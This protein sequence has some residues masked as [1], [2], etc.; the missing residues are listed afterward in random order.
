MPGQESRTEEGLDQ[1]LDHLQWADFA[2]SRHEFIVSSVSQSMAKSLGVTHAD[3]NIKRPFSQYGVDSIT[4][5]DL[6]HQINTHL[7]IVLR[8]TT[9][10]D[11]ANIFDL[12]CFI[13]QNHGTAIDEQRQHPKPKLSKTKDAQ[14]HQERSYHQ[15]IAL[16]RP[17]RIEELSF[18]PLK[19]QEPAANEVQIA[20]RAFSLNF[21]DLLCVK[22]LYP[23]MPEYPFT[24]GFEVS[25]HIA[26]LGSEVSRFVVGDEVIAL[27]GDQLG[28][29]STLLTTAEHLVVSKPREVSHEDACAFPGVFLTVYHAFQKANIKAGEKVLIQGAAG[30]TGLIAVQMALAAGAEIYAT[31][32]SRQKLDYLRERGVPHLINYQTDDFAEVILA[33]TNGY[34]VDVVFNTAAG[35]AIQKGLDILAPNGRY[36]EIAMVALKRSRSLDLSHLVDNQVFYS[37]DMRKLVAK[38]PQLISRYLDRMVEQ[39]AEGSVKPT[40]GARFAI[41]DI[42]KAYRLLEDRKN[43][44]KVVVS[45]PDMIW[46]NHVGQSAVPESSAVED[47]VPESSPVESATAKNLVEQDDPIAVVGMSGRFPGA[48]NLDQF[49]LNLASGKS[50]ITEVPAER[51]DLNQWYDP[52]PAV[53]N[54]THC[55][56]GGFLHDIDKF[57]AL[58]FKLSGREAELTDPQQ[59]LFLEVSWA[60]LEDA[61][62]A[63][64][65]ISNTRCGV[66]VGAGPSDYSTLMREQGVPCEPQSFWGNS[67]S[68]IASRISYFLNLKGPSITIDTACS[69]SLVALHLGCQSI[70]RGECDMVIAGGVYIG[71]TPHFHIIASNAGMLS[72]DGRCKTFDQSAD[73]FVPGEGVGAVVLKPLSAALKAGNFIYGLIRG[74]GSNQDGRTYGIT[75]PSAAS[76]MELEQ[77]V[78]RHAKLDPADISYV[79]AHGT[80]TKLGDPIEIDALSNAFQSKTKKHHDCAIGSVKTNIGHAGAAAGIAGLIKVLLCLQHRQLVPSLNYHTRN[81][82]IDFDNSPFYVNTRLKNWSVA[83]GDLRRAV[84]S[85]FGFSGT[86]AHILLEEYKQKAIAVPGIG[87]DGLGDDRRGKGAGG[88]EQGEQSLSRSRSVSLA[89]PLVEKRSRE[90]ERNMGIK[91]RPSRAFSIGRSTRSVTTSPL[92]PAPRSPA[93]FDKEVLIVLSAK[94]Q[95][96]L[97]KVAENLQSFLAGA[98]SDQ[99]EDIAYTLQVGR[100]A[101]ETRVAFVVDSV[102]HFQQKLAAFLKDQT[103]EEGFYQGQ[104]RDG[105]G[106]PG[107]GSS[108]DVSLALANKQLPQLAHWWVSGVELDWRQLRGA[109]QG[110]LIPL[111]TYPFARDRYW[112]DSAGS[113]AISQAQPSASVLHPLLH[114]LDLQA[115]AKIEKGCVFETWLKSSDP[116]LAQH[117]IE[118]KAV[119]PAVGFLEMIM[120]GLHEIQPDQVALLEDVFWLRPLDVMDQ[121]RV[122]L[123]LEVEQ[124]SFQYRIIPAEGDG[125]VYC[126]GNGYWQKEANPAVQ[127]DVNRLKNQMCKQSVFPESDISVNLGSLYQGATEGWSDGQQALIAFDLPTTSGDRQAP[128]PIQYQFHPAAFVAALQAYGW[129][130]SAPEGLG[131]PFAVQKVELWSDRHQAVYAHVTQDENGKMDVQILDARGQVSV[132][133]RGITLQTL[134]NADQKV[135][136]ETA[137]KNQLEKLLF[138]P[139]WKRLDPKHGVESVWHRPGTSVLL[140]YAHESI[141]EAEKL[142]QSYRQQE[143]ELLCVCL[144]AMENEIDKGLETLAARLRQLKSPLGNICFLD[145]NSQRLD[146]A[147]MPIDESFGEPPTI[148]GLLALVRILN[149]LGYSELPLQWLVLTYRAYAVDQEDPTAPYATAIVGLVSCLAQ[150]HRH[151]QVSVCDR[152]DHTSPWGEYADFPAIANN[153]QTLQVIAQR[154]GHGYVR[155]LEQLDL[156][157]PTQSRLRHKGVYVLVGGA[158]HVGT[159][160]SRY[161]VQTYQAKVIWLG[162]REQN[163]QI[164]KKIAMIAALGSRPQY[165]RLKT[166]SEDDLKR[167]FAQIKAENSMIHGVFNLV[168]VAQGTPIRNLSEAQF[169]AGS[170]DSKVNS[171]Q[172]LYR[173]LKNEALDFMVFFSS[174]QSFAQRLD[175]M[176]AN[177]SSYVAGCMFQDAFVH[178]MNRQLDYPV[179]TINWGY[180]SQ[181]STG[182]EKAQWYETY[183]GNKGVFSLRAGEAMEALERILVNE[184]EQVMVAKVSDE[185]LSDMGFLQDRTVTVSGQHSKE[186]E[187][188]N[189]HLEILIVNGILKTLETLGVLKIFANPCDLEKPRKQAHVLDKYRRLWRELILILVGAGKMEQQGSLFTL[190]ESYGSLEKKIRLIDLEGDARLLGDRYPALASK[191]ALLTPCLNGMADVLNARKQATEV[192]FEHSSLSRVE[193]IYR[194]NPATDYFNQHVADVVTATVQQALPSL[195]AGEKIR[196]LEIGAGT[197]GTSAFLFKALNAY[198]DQLRYIYT[199]ISKRFLIHAQETFCE[200]YSFVETQLLNI[201]EA[202]AE[203]GF[204]PGSI[205]IVV[206]ANVL[207]AT[208]NIGRTLQN[209][210][211]LLKGDGLLVLNELGEVSPFLTVTFGLLDGWWLYDDETIR[212]PGSPAL[213][214]KNWQLMLEKQHFHEVIL[215]DEKAQTLG[216]QIIIAQN[217]GEI[218]EAPAIAHNQEEVLSI[219]IAASVEASLMRELSLCIKIEQSRLNTYTTFSDYGVDS[220]LMLAFVDQINASLGIKLN[221]SELFNY[222]TVERL[223]GFIVDR[224][225]KELSALKQAAQIQENKSE[226]KVTAKAKNQT[227]D[228]A[229]NSPDHSKYWS[230]NVDSHW[231]SPLIP[232]QKGENKEFLAPLL[233]GGW[234]DQL[235]T[236]SHREDNNK[237]DRGLHDIAIIGMSG[238]FPGATNTEQFWQNLSAG[239]HSV[240]ELPESRLDRQIYSPQLETG[241]CYCKWGGI[242]EE[243]AYFDPLFFEISPKEAAEMNPSQRVF[244]QEAYRALEDAGLVN[245]GLS[246]LHCGVYVGCEPNGYTKQGFTGS[247]EALVASRISYFLN[248]QGPAL[249]INSGCS[250]SLVAIHLACESL[251]HGENDIALAGGVFTNLNSELLVC[252]SSIEMLSS[253]GKCCAFD[254]A[255]NGTVLGEGVSV[256]VLKKLQSALDDGDLIYGVI[257][258]S[259]INQ[260]GKSN[261]ITAPNGLAQEKLIKRI[262]QDYKIDASKISY[263]EAHGT[264]TKLG[265]PVEANALKK[266]FSSINPESGFHCGVGSVKSNIG[267]PAAAAGAI[268]LVKVL[269]C[270]KH[271][272]LP[273]LVHFNQLNPFI[274]FNDTGLYIV[275]QL[276]DWEAEPGEPLM[277]GINSFGHS[278]TNAHLVIQEAPVQ[279]INDSKKAFYLICLSAKT[280]EALKHKISDLSEYLARQE[281]QVTLGAIAY[282]LNTG[283]A[284]FKKRCA[285]VVDSLEALQDALTG[286]LEGLV[287]NGSKMSPQEQAFAKKVF[288]LIVAD[289]QNTGNL[290]TGSDQTIYKDNLMA[291][292]GLY[293]KGF[294]LDWQR[295]YQGQV[296]RRL[297][298][299]TYPFAKEAYWINEPQKINF[300]EPLADKPKDQA[301]L[302]GQF[303]L[304]QWKRLEKGT[305]D[306]GLGTGDWE[307]LEG[308]T[309][310]NLVLFAERLVEKKTLPSPQSPVPSPR[311]PLLADK[312]GRS[313]GTL[314]RPVELEGDR[315]K[316]A[317]TPD[318]VVI[319][320]PQTMSGVKDDLKKCYEQASASQVVSFEVGDTFASELNV[321][322][323]HAFELAL[324]SPKLG[325]SALLEPGQ[326]LTLYFLMPEA[327]QALNLELN[328]QRLE[329]NQSRGL[330]ALFRLIQA[331]LADH[332]YSSELTLKIVTQQTQACK[333]SERIAPFGADVVG[334]VQSLTK[335]YELW[336]VSCVDI[337]R[338]TLW[339]REQ[340]K[341]F[342][343][344]LTALKPPTNGRVICWREGHFYHNVLTQANLSSIQGSSFKTHGVY[345]IIGGAGGLGLVLSEYL[346][347]TVQAKL[348]W[349][350]RRSVEALTPLAQQLLT[351]QGAKVL[352]QQGDIGD[353]EAMRRVV[354]QAKAHFG[355]LDGVIHSALVLEDRAIA[356]MDE[357]T[358][359]KVLTPKVQGNVVLQQAL[360]DEPLDFLLFFS[361][362]Q[363]FMSHAGQSN[364]ASACTFED[365]WAQSQNQQQNYPVKVINWGYWGEVGI[366]ATPDHRQR[367]ARQG[368]LSINPQEGMEVV[369]RCLASCATQVAYFKA[370]PSTLSRLGLDNGKIMYASQKSVSPALIH[371]VIAATQ[372]LSMSLP[373]GQRYQQALKQLDRLGCY[374]L[375]RAFQTMGVFCQPGE[376]YEQQALAARLG[377]PE[378]YYQLY[379]E[380]LNLLDKAGFI[381]M[382]GLHL[383]VQTTLPPENDEHHNWLKS[384]PELRSHEKLLQICVQAYP[385]IIQ[386]SV[387]ATDIMFPE[388]SME[389]VEGIYQGNT[390]A[391]ALNTK[392]RD[393]AIAYVKA[394]LADCQKESGAFMQSKIIF[395]EVGAGTGGMSSEVLKGLAPYREY[396]EYY[397]TDISEH[398]VQYGRRRYGEDYPFVRFQR[399]D[400]EQEREAVSDG[401]PNA[402]DVV[403][404]ANVLHA[405]QRVRNTIQHVKALLKR[406]GLLI[407]NEVTTITSFATLTF[408]LLEGWWRYQ[409]AI[410]RM[411]G[412]P[413]LSAPMWHRLLEEEG[414]AKVVSL[415]EQGEGE[416]LGQQIIVGQSDGWSLRKNTQKQETQSKEA[417]ERGAGSKGEVVTD[418]VLRPIENALEGRGLIPMF[419][420][421][422][423]LLFSTRGCANETLRER[424]R[425]CSPCS[426][427]PAPPPLL[428]KQTEPIAITQVKNAYSPAQLVQKVTAQI[429]QTLAE[430]LDIAS[431]RVELDVPFSEYGVDSILSVSIINQLNQRLG[432][433]LKRPDLFNYTT[434]ESMAAH[435]VETF[436]DRLTESLAENTEKPSAVAAPKKTQSKSQT[437]QGILQTNQEPI[438][439]IGMSACL[440]GADNV[441]TFWDNLV[442]GKNSVTQI[443]R[444]RYQRES[445]ND[446]PGSPD[447]SQRQAGFMANIAEF[448]PLFFA[449]S[450]QEA[451]WMDPAQRLFLQQA[452]S[453]LEDAGYNPRALEGT[454]C[455]V[456]VGCS[457]TGYGVKEGERAGY[458]PYAMTNSEAILPAR[459]SY[460]LDLKGPSIPINTACSSSLVAIHLA[461]EQLRS[462]QSDIALAGGASALIGSA[463]HIGLK[464][465]GMLS[466]DGLCKA[467]DRGANGFVL[468]EAVGVVVLKPLSSALADGDSIHGLIIGSAINQDGK[469]NGIMAPN[470]P[471]QTA[472]IESVYR[473]FQ[474]DPNTI[475]YIETHGTGTQLGDPIEVNALAAAYQKFTTQ[476]QYCAIGSVKTNIGHTTTAAGVCGLIKTLLCLKNKKLVP[477]LHYNQPNENI[478]FAQTPF[479]VNTQVKDWPGDR[480]GIRCAAVSSF[481]YSGTNAHIVVEEF[482]ETRTSTVRQ[483]G[484]ALIVLSARN[485]ARLK[486]LASNLRADL[487][488]N[489]QV[490]LADVAY[491]LQVGRQAMSER[492]AFVADSVTDIV[493]HLADFLDGKANTQDLYQGKVKSA[494]DKSDLLLEGDAGQAFINTILKQQDYRKLATLWVAGTSWDWNLLYGE[495][496]PRR[497]SLPSYPFARE[498]YWLDG[499]VEAKA[500][501][502]IPILYEDAP[503]YMRNEPQRAQRTQREKERKFGAASQRNG[504]TRDQIKR[505]TQIEQSTEL[506]TFEEVWQE[507]PLSDASSS[508]SY[509]S[510]VYFLSQSENQQAMLKAMQAIDP[511]INVIFIAQGDAY[512]KHSSYT[513]TVDSADTQSYRQVFTDIGQNHGQVDALLYLWPTEDSRCLYNPAAIA[514]ILQA[515]ANSALKPSR[516]L[517]VASFSTALERCYLESWLGFDRSLKLMM[518][519]IQVAGLYQENPGQGQT[520]SMT[521]WSQNIFSE[522]KTPKAQTV[523]IQKHRRYVCQ[524]QKTVLANQGTSVA[525]AVKPGGTYLITGGC[526]GLGFLVAQHLAQQ[527]PTTNLIL[528]GRSPL[529]E[530]IQSKLTRLGTNIY[531]I[532]ADICDSIAM[533]NGI[534]QAKNRFGD[535]HGIFHVAGI[536]PSAS[537]LDKNIADFQKVLAPKVAGTLLLDDLCRDEPLDFICYFSSSAAI[538]GDFGACDYAIGNRFQMAYAAYRHQLQQQGRRQGKALAINW[539]LWREG[540]MGFNH[541]E[542]TKMYLQSSGQR[543][544]ETQEG[545]AIL[546]K[547]LNQNKTQHLVLVGQPSR[548]HGFL[549]LTQAPVK[550]RQGSREQGAESKGEE[551]SPLPPA[552]RPSSSFPCPIPPTSSVNQA[553][554]RPELRGLSLE[555]SV[556]WDLKNIIV[557]QLKVP[558]EQLERESNLADFGFDS[559]SL[560]SFATRLGEHYQ[561]EIT[562]ALFFGY[563][564]LEQLTEYFLSKH[565]DFI[566]TFYQDL[567]K[568]EVHSP[569][570]PAEENASLE[571]FSEELRPEKTDDGIEEAIAI[572]GMSGRF[573]KAY[574]IEQMWKILAEGECAVEEIPPNYFDWRR[575]YG[576]PKDA[577]KTNGKWCASIPGVAEFD[578]LF[579]QISPREAPNIDPRQRHLLQESWNALENAGYG[580]DHLNS[581]KIGT[582]VGAEE[583]DYYQRVKEGNITSNHSGILA[584]RLAY[585]LNLKGPTMTINTACSSSLVAT[586]QACLSLRQRECDTAIAAGVNLML[587]P[588]G[589]ISMAQAGMLSA[590]GRCYAFDQRAN[591]LVPG[592]AVVVV[593]LKRLSRALTDGDPIHGLILAS[594]VNYDGKTNGITA[595]S[596]VSQSELVKDVYRRAGVSPQNIDYIVTH[597]TG[598]KLGDPVEL[599][600]LAEVFQGSKHPCA[601]SSSKT[602]FGHTFSASGLVSLVS[603]VQSLRHKTLPKSLHFAEQNDFVSWDKSNLYVN[604]ANQPWPEQ[605]GK[606]RIGAVSAFGMSGTNAHLL[607]QG[608]RLSRKEQPIA[609]PYSLLVLSAKTEEALQL[610]VKA[611]IQFLQEGLVDNA[612]LG[613]ISYTL[614]AGRHHFQHR[615][616]IVVQDLADAIYS[617]T[618][619]GHSD[620]KPNIFQGKVPTEFTG[621]KVTWNYVNELVQK[622]RLS[623]GDENLYRENLFGLA[624]FYCQGYDIPWSTLYGDTPLRRI[625]L[626][627]YPFSR[628]HFWLDF[629]PQS[630]GEQVATEISV[631]ESQKKALKELIP[632]LYED[633]PN[634]MRNEPQRTQREKE[635]KFGATSQRNGISYLLK[636]EQQPQIET[637][638]KAS[639][640]VLLVYF[641]SPSQFE[642]TLANFL[643]QQCASQVIEIQLG[644]ETKQ[645]SE[646][647][648]Y[649][650]VNTPAGFETCL[651]GYSQTINSFYFLCGDRPQHTIQEN[652]I[653]LLRLVRAMKQR[654]QNNAFIDCTLLTLDNYRVDNSVTSPNDGG[655]SGLG[656]SVAQG[657]HRFRVRNIDLSREDMASAEKQLPLPAMI[658][659][660]APS[661]RGEVTKLQSGWRYKQRFFKL[662]WQSLQGLKPQAA[663][664]KT[665]GVYVL[666]G[667]AGTVGTIIT[668]YLIQKYQAKVVWLGRSAL[669]SAAVQEKLQAF[670]AMDERNAPL[671]IQADVTDESSMAQAVKQIKQH[672][673]RINGAVFSALVFKFDNSIAQTSEAE[674]NQVLDTKKKGAAYFYTAFQNEALDFMCYFSSVQAFSFLSSRDSAGYAAGITSADTFVHSIDK[675]AAFPVG[676]I[677]WGYWQA[678][679]AGTEAEKRLAG[680]YDLISDR[681]GCQFFDEFIP[682]LTA[683]LVKQTL[684]LGV[685]KAVEGLMGCDPTQMITLNQPA[686][687]SLIH[688]LFNENEVHEEA[689]IAR[690]LN[691]DFR[692]ELHDWLPRLLFSQIRQLGIFLKV[693]EQQESTH[694]QKQAGVI[695]KYGRWWRECCLG[696][697]ENY[698]Y[699]QCKGD[700]VEVATNITVDDADKL[701]Q[702]WENY[703]N[704]FL[705]NPEKKAVLELLDSCLRKLPQI[706]RGSIQ[707][708]DILFPKSSMEKVENMYQRNSLS[709]YFNTFVAKSAEAYI[710]QRI[711]ADPQTRIRILEIGAGTGGTTALVLP[712][713]R[714]LGHAIDE[715]CYTDLSKAFLMHA[716]KTYGLDYSYLDYK[717]L[718]I[719]QAIATQGIE[720]GAYDIVI[721]TNVLHATKNIRQT[722]RHAKTALKRN[723]LLLLNEVVEK[724][725][726]GTLTFGLLDGWWLYQDEELRIPGSPLIE[727]E[728]WLKILKEEGFTSTLLPAQAAY[729]LGQ[730]VMVSESD[731][732]VKQDRERSPR[733]VESSPKS[734]VPVVQPLTPEQPLAQRQPSAETLREYVAKL[735]LKHLAETLNMAQASIDPQVS[736]SDYGIDSILGVG[737]ID[738]L[739][740]A[741][742]ITMNTAILFDYTNVTRLSHYLVD[743]Y[744]EKIQTKLQK[745]RVPPLDQNIN[746]YTETKSKPENPMPKMASDEG[747]AEICKDIAVI[748][749]SGQFPGAKDLD[750]FWQNLIQGHD[751]VAEFPA[752][753]LNPDLFSPHK[754]A[755]KTDCKWGG[756]LE[757]RDCFDPLFFNITPREAESMNP[758]QR[759]ILSESW[760]ALEDA[761]YNPKNLE[762]SRVSVFIGAEPTD[763]I[764]ETFTGSSDAI[765]ASRL[766]YYLNLKGP[767]LVVNT[768]CSSSALAIHLACESLRSGE[769][770]MALAGGIFAAMH[771]KAIVKLAEIDMLSSTGRCRTFDKS[772][773]GTVLSEGVG[774][775]VLKRLKDAIRDKDPIYGVIQA[776]GANQDGAS[777][778]I[779]APSGLSQEELLTSV[780][781]QYQI[782]PESISYIEAHGTGTRLGDTVEANALKRAFK[783]FS[784]QTQ[785]CALGSAKSHIGHTGA[786]SGVIG[787]IKILLSIRHRQLPKMLHFEELNP[788]IALE[789]SAFYINNQHLEWTNQGGPLT[790]AL[791]SFGHSG[792]N[793]H[794]VVREHL[795]V[796]QVKVEADSV[797]IPLSAKTPACLKAYAEKLA[798]F[799]ENRRI[800]KTTGKEISLTDL[801]FTL[802]LGREAMRERCIFLARNIP[803]LVAQLNAFASS[804]TLNDLSWHGRVGHSKS[805][806]VFDDRESEQIIAQ[807]MQKG[808]LEKVAAAWV[809]GQSIDWSVLYRELT[810]DKIH[811][812]T[813]PFAEE[814]YWKP[815]EQSIAPETIPVSFGTLMLQPCWIEQTVEN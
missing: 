671:Y 452:W 165:L 491:T 716:Q 312:L 551:F 318:T 544:L 127:L 543:V 110:H 349:V 401:L 749:M 589:Y 57:D 427:P 605:P 117:L 525:S 125:G 259:G 185:V 651:Q 759:L 553:S 291:I 803:D 723:G 450:P 781:R 321:C 51:W 568:T 556:L 237:S 522:L 775:V 743:T 260:D 785:F 500:E 83:Q 487:N 270:M 711:Q 737:F 388:A 586:H 329:D 698:G 339:T 248:L 740:K 717:L 478:E 70:Q 640:V 188:A 61:G 76:Q 756:I 633:A 732:F 63:N 468:G 421:A 542:N 193:D 99:L 539:P 160:L 444:D 510:V 164:E 456:F 770:S 627:G 415:G 200:H 608:Y 20:V 516:F 77:S 266:V 406:H 535:I 225:R 86:N 617:W 780:Y 658:L 764:H 90:A 765:V 98:V 11:H 252:L 210:K 25:G 425:D 773:D 585:F 672:Y 528:T 224:Y 402:C 49:W 630:H 649:C 192:L 35:D 258:G 282:T 362:G 8:T 521:N 795:S 298:L 687:D 804:E 684:C 610:K 245:E 591:G 702:G 799:L 416:M 494:R 264:G 470:G 670:Q 228:T 65:G 432:I 158:G 594:G 199:D 255:A 747:K 191:L 790:A 346:L 668:R 22:G 359:H 637:E 611:M 354:Q 692:N 155:Q 650:D 683:G 779:T 805:N 278:G 216:Q 596:G 563:S 338:Q 328:L 366:V 713:L 56:W 729:K 238:Q 104:L 688:C 163:E 356:D 629:S 739:A 187:H 34:G 316:P 94:N 374:L 703:Q 115:S 246:Q 190:Q 446:L 96:R 350:G 307:N 777:N 584:A 300:T 387:A 662:D 357:K 240:G 647:K 655:I 469:T 642:K 462:G 272:Q 186:P 398:F 182:V 708:T 38:N 331:L 340:S 121:L 332:W 559:I 378:S 297:S 289:L 3:I 12:S 273:G 399:L 686:A 4:G 575:Y 581:Q 137:K 294:D 738:Q 203:Q 9:L 685:S 624:D 593:V 275:E 55:K 46:E 142:M 606:K 383:N 604:T 344:A 472:L 613:D 253:S 526:G 363:S 151:W 251:R 753:Y 306:W 308:D 230:V 725:I 369:E 178:Q 103:D 733:E 89:Q 634:Y 136:K 614:F 768:G 802:Q 530:K 639:Q 58:F 367:M 42:Q 176:S 443:P 547:I 517:L 786:A 314:A 641:E 156:P 41:A 540:G 407:L 772:C 50:S 458:V 325:L 495:N 120:A 62:H 92:L 285:F 341:N 720:L 741:F 480:N 625:N 778:G 319:F 48:D 37:I 7:G 315:A 161:L 342:A 576:D 358:L 128:D 284:H 19:S 36:L 572:I 365:A 28:G 592:E 742:G 680:H 784:D 519:G 769:S 645:V 441:Q 706:L 423:R 74:S 787:L 372:T 505:E 223:T 53:L 663:G 499:V 560:L 123:V 710:R 15:A 417:G 59:R 373:D 412:G 726:I 814:H 334:F 635:R 29:H 213:S 531:Y 229:S 745:K 148:T 538:L 322:D 184:L 674:F 782:N 597:G 107:T 654:I 67:S 113:V 644:L 679:L 744:A 152:Q 533:R 232:L 675:S 410:V 506:M 475:G 485:E 335:E 565:S 138:V 171:A 477:S 567:A 493:E 69:S 379:K 375:L 345:L 389:L 665:G 16:E 380:W 801:A 474:I 80:G 179:K 126:R 507:Q 195:G 82:H 302:G 800:S 79:E 114:R 504:I 754:Q 721:A 5:V 131:M 490:Q 678:S 404:A 71:T 762:N 512:A 17:S 548:V 392:A 424:D 146:L 170:F 467:F 147:D 529:D 760:K 154:N 473:K 730:Q 385:D 411:P 239:I 527:Q 618:Q 623:S 327:D 609:P 81:E 326:A 669:T 108:Q 403:L 451:Q 109:A 52:D 558:W 648:W 134:N 31:A 235:L 481:G 682:M 459:I 221:P 317:I 735:I 296:Y 766:S 100:E 570:A 368:V 631:A 256:L 18:H 534:A 632:I 677:N 438:A 208:R 211:T 129:I 751:G 771:E 24:P 564:T 201:E 10:F 180:W 746:T 198:S 428:S 429:V 106:H 486:N 447:T 197:G 355:H 351:A 242:L 290:E 212:L 311:A 277:A 360:A 60:A 806:N 352:Y 815:E 580:A 813:Y 712:Q 194:G 418:L 471:S 697:L 731:G 557:H 133:Y 234:G 261:G 520:I 727:L 718:N 26:K 518:P 620:R 435:I 758:H 536:A 619:S 268:S 571:S 511:I 812:P 162:R 488:K 761:G 615:L 244:M 85:S 217:K 537:I 337:N 601:I 767:A 566:Q 320:Y 64:N 13:D 157:C 466:A 502:L 347:E 460:F 793:V 132:R 577:N 602:N 150:E 626:P 699:V 514:H 582:F 249:V 305:G 484:T 554:T 271:R 226:I 448:D 588:Y 501:D 454:S 143:C 666:M 101:M 437:P 442:A 497:I 364:Y 175:F 492:L 269:L 32:G 313:R 167:V 250:S 218:E 353:L 660:E 709:D 774:V 794:L 140:V 288:D 145:S 690:L 496:R 426:L 664:L 465:A 105:E 509:K 646:D 72:A 413:L 189:E 95:E 214:A 361:A 202:V 153:T 267:H 45:V 798:A 44:G 788:A 433:R 324:A 809:Q 68:L 461:C 736:F 479:Y 439:V 33:D 371:A 299:P 561:L 177:M 476:T 789:D 776:S 811:I 578:P 598:T 783:Q 653:Q 408:G 482:V 659:S 545:L 205:D 724:S 30:G 207:H 714:Q 569:E 93:S 43:I 573:P 719:E 75:A 287:G 574:D 102:P 587:T 119:F 241:K 463:L 247:S 206:A 691:Q 657:D 196:I 420:S 612:T 310:L 135:G 47:R 555:Q 707:A 409:D 396:I 457:A 705:D 807:W 254:E 257:K 681:E 377:I 524:I 111:P 6:I 390:A 689:E 87:S 676:I 78:Y 701:W 386:G 400:I 483:Q 453:A 130:H 227:L 763:Y 541:D 222:T 348:V 622:I 550:Q 124:N 397:Y 607:V 301:T 27:A 599:N 14:S 652:E 748:G 139:V 166:G 667:G 700:R 336:Q 810:A 440:P 393:A 636:W 715:Y 661:D 621:Q 141:E 464:G 384:Y 436:G 694:W 23:T 263:I 600:A 616:A 673:P 722:L 295:I 116:L 112:F 304:P 449:I 91:P 286:T 422:S 508:A 693:G 66:F 303:Y 590:D 546:D 233:K 750:T 262:Y 54:K 2:E 231:R 391:D 149:E 204:D 323:R 755:G 243:Q 173:V 455:A 808:K 704:S 293:L 122:Q 445:V 168:M 792:T 281:K 498:S 430:A 309:D 169:R 381:E 628:Q 656:Y 40:I 220:I 274:D 279:T 183:I 503:N 181:E 159:L 549:G 638:I 343:E 513:Y 236:E 292:A 796:P 39:L 752:N 394:R 97:K 276:Q 219:E 797:L 696:L 734:A 21:G 73:G 333:A 791:N 265:D 172:T 118:G 330:I 728:C 395:L 523:L 489:S 434:T 643:Q 144:S 757:Q 603:L 515:L 552:P 84:V 414:F 562:P 283:R 695:E 595:P 405:T 382:N 174:M 280:D 419:R 209:V 431:T 532:Q 88:R 579:F 370:Q 1:R 583:G 376:Q 215:F